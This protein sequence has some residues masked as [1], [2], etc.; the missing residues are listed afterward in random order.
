MNYTDTKE[1]AYL[2]G[3]LWADGYI[4]GRKI[5]IELVEDDLILLEPLFTA[6]GE[7]T[8][9]RRERTNR[10]KQMS[11]TIQ[12]T[13]LAEWVNKAGFDSKSTVTAKHLIE[14][15]P[16]ELRCYWF[17]GYFDGDGCFYHG[18]NSVNHAV[19]SANYNQDLSF[20]TDLLESLDIIYKYQLLSK[21]NPK[22]MKLNSH[23][24]VRLSGRAPVLAFGSY[25]YNGDLTIGLQR[26]YLK[27]K[28]CTKELKILRNVVVDGIELPLNKQLEKIGITYGSFN[29]RLNSGW[30][31]DKALT[32]P[33]KR[34]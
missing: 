7:Y 29:D 11:I 1:K 26:K 17:R 5:G 33:N 32:T 6:F 10:R 2:L 3:L 14:Q 30:S 13:K 16:L 22:T 31:L 34:R 28:E 27:F 24:R 8:I 25:I 21:Q 12:D 9:Y 18:K 19:L 23:S 15:I 4:T 20:F